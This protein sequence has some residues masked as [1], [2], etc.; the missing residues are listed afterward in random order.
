MSGALWAVV[1]GAGF[2]L[3]QAINREAVRGMDVYI[4]TFIQ[5]VVSAVV[6]IAISLL[7]EDV[8][9]LF[10]API[11][12]ILNFAIAGFLHFLI[13]W[14]FLNASQKR[15]GAAR[16]SPLIGTTP[17]FAAIIAALT[18]HEFPTLWEL[19]GIGIIV[20]G[21]YLVSAPDETSTNGEKSTKRFSVSLRAASLALAA[22]FCW[23]LS[24]I[25]IRYGLQGLDSPLLGVTVG[26]TASALGYAVV[27]LWQR[28]RWIG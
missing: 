10:N 21:I 24:P 23:S 3:F 15:I 11:S 1:A 14:T 16:T 2:G 13:G 26:V 6:L 20:F 9:L 12:A 7:T 28:D 8:R 27:L 5:L 18:F 22:S 19:I 17:L 25:F 4:A